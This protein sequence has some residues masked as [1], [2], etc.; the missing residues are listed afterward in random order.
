MLY[1]ALQL[2][3]PAEMGR[4]LLA[5]GVPHTVADAAER[6]SGASELVKAGSEAVVD[7]LI[8]YAEVDAYFRRWPCLHSMLQAPG[9]T[10]F[11]LRA[12]EDEL[13]S[14]GASPARAEMRA[15]RERRQSRLTLNSTECSGSSQ[16]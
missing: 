9:P 1:E 2:N 5:I 3:L 10:I 13:V 14:I 15:E 12:C 8:N 6:H 16:L 7:Q 4:L 11:R